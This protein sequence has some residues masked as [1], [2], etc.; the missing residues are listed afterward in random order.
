M[1]AEPKLL[2]RLGF[3]ISVIGHVAV[4]TLGLFFAGANPFDS[5]PAEAI[6]V[7]IV[8]PDEIAQTEPPPPPEMPPA[9][10]MPA[11]TAPSPAP[12]PA[13]SAAAALPQPAPNPSP[14]PVPRPN[15]ER[16]A[17]QAAI[18]PPWQP[19][20]PARPL[21]SPQ[22][23]P[24]SAEPQ[25]PNIG[26]QLNIGDMFGLPLALPDGRLG[27]G[28]DAPAIDKANVA[29]D[30]II[31]FRKHLKTCSTLPDGINT[32]GDVK[33]VLRIQ[34]KPDGT[35]A[36]S[37]QPIRIEG[38]SRGGGAL[39]LSAVTA[40]RKCQPYNMLPP[41]KYNEWKVLDLSF[42]PQNFGGG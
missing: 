36:T 12:P 16:N 21:P 37:P 24:P 29:S 11:L 22:P 17:R 2:M 7:D 9:F 14:Q 28:F 6:T 18:Q 42:T 33:A 10:E 35:L 3:A 8:S 23:P 13:V 4:L 32:T 27:G 25:Q 30:E 38:V 19:A 34:L 31:A 20:E 41:D 5:V 26:E 15:P 1:M 40:L 39:Y